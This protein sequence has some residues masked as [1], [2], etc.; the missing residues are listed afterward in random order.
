MSQDSLNIVCFIRCYMTASQ[1]KKATVIPCIHLFHIFTNKSSSMSTKVSLS[2]FTFILYYFH[3]EPF[4]LL[5]SLW[6]LHY[7]RHIIS[8]DWIITGQNSY[9]T[10]ILLDFYQKTC[11]VLII[12]ITFI[13][14][15][16]KNIYLLRENLFMFITMGLITL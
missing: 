3:K 15:L 11:Q 14:E 12:T 5:F 2:I 6:S 1:Y 10:F 16:L 8:W 4:L 13:L 7:E 9:L